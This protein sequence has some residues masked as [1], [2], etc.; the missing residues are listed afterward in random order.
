MN[1]DPR[2]GQQIADVCWR[3]AQQEGVPQ[4]ETQRSF[5]AKLA[6]LVKQG[7]ILF[8][9]TQG[10]V[11]FIK[12]TGKGTAEIHTFTVEDGRA[13]IKAYVFGAQVAKKNGVKHITSYADSPA[14]VKLA[15]STGL[16]VKISQ[17]TKMQNGEMRPM[18]QFDLEL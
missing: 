3:S 18:Y 16:P 17:T 14:F 10:T 15:K 8:P 7:A 4:G 5:I 12:P 9:V 1:D 2:V 6:K 11:L 13:L